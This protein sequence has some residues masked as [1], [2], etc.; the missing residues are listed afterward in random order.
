MFQNFSLLV[1]KTKY[2]ET[3][4]ILIIKIAWNREYDI[5]AFTIQ[6]YKFFQNLD[7]F[8]VTQFCFSGYLIE[9][10]FKILSEDISLIAE[11]QSPDTFGI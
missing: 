10:F 6:E 7:F 11:F 5:Y 9:N 3:D 1:N 8:T 2:L 4:A